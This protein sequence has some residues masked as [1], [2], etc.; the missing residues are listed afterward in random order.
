M[1]EPRGAEAD[2]C[3]LEPVTDIHQPVGIVD[4]EPVIEDLAMPT[5]LFRPHDPDPS[6]DAPARLVL[7]VE[8]CSEA[9]ARVVAGSRHQDEV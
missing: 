4:L 6:L 3:R 5:M 1:G 8:K 9:L 2:L 7:V